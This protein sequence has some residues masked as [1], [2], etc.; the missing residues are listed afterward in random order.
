MGMI[1]PQAPVLLRQPNCA[2]E[3]VGLKAI[4]YW[5]SEEEPHLPH[6][7]DFIWKSSD[8]KSVYGGDW[9]EEQRSLAFYLQMGTTLALWR[10]PAKCR[11][12]PKYLGISDQGD[13]VF[14][15]PDGLDHYVSAHNVR[16][17]PEFAQHVINTVNGN[18]EAFKARATKLLEER[19]DTFIYENRCQAPDGHE[20]SDKYW[21]EWRVKNG[22]SP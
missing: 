3:L 19:I 9:Q 16:L 6:P 20:Y 4:G 11:L 13:G 5:Y 2:Q 1:L 22:L 17:D 14:C 21:A 15:W 18:P 8:P 12:C 7:K 10:G